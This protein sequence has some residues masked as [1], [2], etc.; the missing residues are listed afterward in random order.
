MP[1]MGGEVEGRGH[2]E[3]G[4]KRDRKELLRMERRHAITGGM[5]F[6]VWGG[7]ESERE[8]ER[9]S[10]RKRGGRGRIPCGFYG[11][12]DRVGHISY[13]TTH[14]P[15]QFTINCAMEMINGRT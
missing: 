14:T 2:R 5:S 1:K 12:P 11:H 7:R 4:H 6:C 10:A 13:Q 15:V 8:K 3:T 9:G